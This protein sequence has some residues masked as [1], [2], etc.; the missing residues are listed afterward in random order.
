MAKKKKPF[1]ELEKTH[2][3]HIDKAIKTLEQCNEDCKTYAKAITEWRRKEKA[4]FKKRLKRDPRIKKYLKEGVRDLCVREHYRPGEKL[5]TAVNFTRVRY[6]IGFDIDIP[7]VNKFPTPPKWLNERIKDNLNV[8]YFDKIRELVLVISEE[9]RLVRNHLRSLYR[10]AE[11][12]HKVYITVYESDSI[13][14]CLKYQSY[15]K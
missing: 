15:H 13:R 9:I 10:S 8:Y 11:G 6:R 14:K 3:I 12:N 1:I 7:F 4:A 2:R 5:G